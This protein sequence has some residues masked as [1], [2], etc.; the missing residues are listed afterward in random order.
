MRIAGIPVRFD[1][2]F[3]IVATL[4]LLRGGIPVVVL[5]LVVLGGSVLVHEMGHALVARTTGA[6]PEIVIHALGGL[7]SWQPP[8]DVS[9]ARRVAIS[10]AGPGAGI[11]LGLLFVAAHRTGVGTSGGL[12]AL[13]I[14]FGIYINIGYG[15]FNLLPIVPLDGGQTLR[16][17]LP[18]SPAQRER[19]AAIVS[20]IVGAGVIAAAVFVVHQP[21]A[22]FFVAFFVAVNV[23]T[24]Q[25]GRRTPQRRVAREAT[26]VAEAMRLR[27]AGE[28]AAAAA[29]A[30]QVAQDADRRGDHAAAIAA[31]Q[32][33]A[34]ARLDAGEPAEA[35][36]LLLDLPAG[37]VDPLLEGRVL[38]A[39]GQPALGVE[40]LAAA[41]TARPADDSAYH[42]AAGLV[43]T[44]AIDRLLATFAAPHVPAAA[45]ISAAIGAIDVGAFA[46]A[47][48]LAELAGSH[49]TGAQFGFAAYTAARAWARAGE[50]ERA[51]LALRAA[52]QNEV[53]Y[54]AAA[55]SEDAFWSLRG[56]DYDDIVRA[57]S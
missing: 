17:L 1:M 19:A 49:A 22:A 21:V 26:G 7:T 30:E 46:V 13:A 10:L 42:L 11:A 56:P 15:L 32:F 44:G 34:A 35:K 50:R 14:S 55:R 51:L 2:W 41:F 12:P 53:A 16:D 18:G 48:R 8:G 54:A 43:R 31:V 45:V 40:R 47:G 4:L 38:V 24:L 9:R 25:G 3:F 36:R 5:W 23:A 6:S 33:A 28:P 39:I 29:A 57:V 52:V 27:E 20:I 37:S